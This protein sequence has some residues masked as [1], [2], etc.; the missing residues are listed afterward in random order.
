MDFCHYR[1]FYLTN[2][3]NNYWISG[4][5]TLKTAPK[6]LIHKAPEATG[7]FLRNKIADPAAKSYNNK[8]LTKLLLMRI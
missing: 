6:K 8:I 2:M 7:E 1:K 4:I 5:N 3:E